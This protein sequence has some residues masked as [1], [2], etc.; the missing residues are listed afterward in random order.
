MTKKKSK[1]DPPSKEFK[2][3][4]VHASS[5]AIDCELCGRTHFYNYPN[6]DWEEGEYKDLCDGYEKEPDK[7]IPWGDYVRWGNIDGKQ[8]VVDCECNG[9][10]RYEEWILSHRFIISDFL[11]ERAKNKIIEA[12]MEADAASHLDEVSDASPKP[13]NI[14]L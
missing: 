3:A 4:I 8:A 1:P 7:Y 10:R 14:T 2:Q 5:I 9:L 13:R 11:R 6:L 12:N